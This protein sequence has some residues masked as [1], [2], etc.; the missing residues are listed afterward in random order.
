MQLCERAETDNIVL[1]ACSIDDLDHLLALRMEVLSCVFADED[2]L[3]DSDLYKM[4]CEQNRQYY[5]TH[6]CDGSHI[7]YIASNAITNDVV[8]TGGLC[9]YQEM[10]S[11][12][13]PNGQCGYLMNIYT[14]QAAR[15]KGVARC[16][17]EKL[18]ACAR[19]RE[20]TKIYLETTAMARPLYE[21]LGF[22]AMDGY[23]RLP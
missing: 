1:H 18:I 12:D 16:V 4:L 7:A 20:V 9:L 14:R 5:Q 15:G 3:S 23:L 8:G 19:A 22:V 10:P 13:N 11:P 6:L 2:I 21:S 17:V